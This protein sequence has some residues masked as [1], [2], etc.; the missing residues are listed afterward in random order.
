MKNNCSVVQ[1]FTL[2]IP[3]MTH[4]KN[5]T[6]NHQKNKWNEVI[7]DDWG[8]PVIWETVS[9]NKVKWSQISKTTAYT[10]RIVAAGIVIVGWIVYGV[11][12]STLLASA[13]NANTGCPMAR[14][15]DQ[16][17]TSCATNTNTPTTTP[18]D[19]TSTP[20]SANSSTYETM[21][22]WH[23]AYSLVPA[24]VNLVAGKSYKLIIT[25]SANGGGC[26]NTMTIPGLDDN[27]YPVKKDTPVTITIDNAKAG[28]YEVI[29][30]AMG[31]HQGNIVIQ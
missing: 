17:W 13:W 1:H 10:G 31:M 3:E 26:M 22:I 6:L 15:W 11:L 21:N 5:Y 12:S 14:N 7:L 28:N 24:T 18:V 8:M 27:V 23:D 16:Q 30:G 29:C 2:L 9:T 4:K 20:T 19:T 25:P